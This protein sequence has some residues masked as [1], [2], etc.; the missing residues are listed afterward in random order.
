[1]INTFADASL[2]GLHPMKLY[3]GKGISHG[4]ADRL[5]SKATTVVGR[6]DEVAECGVLPGSAHD[7]AQGDPADQ[8]LGPPGKDPKAVPPILRPFQKTLLDLLALSLE[9]EESVVSH[10]LEG[11]QELTLS[12]SQIEQGGCVGYDQGAEVKFGPVEVHGWR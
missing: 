1:L 2:R 10:G 3:L 6:S 11:G 12:D 7:V 5:G 4:Q 8:L 9:R